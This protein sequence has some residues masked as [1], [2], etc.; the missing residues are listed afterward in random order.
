[1]RAK[2]TTLFQQGTL[3][4][5]EVRTRGAVNLKILNPDGIQL[6]VINFPCVLLYTEKKR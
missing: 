2:R 6:N 1:M 3:K 5:R 4:K